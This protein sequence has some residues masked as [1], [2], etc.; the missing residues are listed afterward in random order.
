MADQNSIVTQNRKARHEYHL[1]DK[2]EAGL[3]LVGSEVK[4][5]REGRANLK[6][7]YV[8]IRRGEAVLVSAHISP[9]S[10]TGFTG[11]EPDRDRRLLLNKREILKIN[12]KISEKGF[13]VIPLKIYFKNG[14]AKVEIAVAKGKNFYD[15]R[16]ARKAK[17][18][19]RD[20][21]RQLRNYR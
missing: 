7:S 17:D 13:T 4:S 8:I 10:H 18:V 12:Q 9:Y 11:H 20:T 19:E 21:Q 16:D 14:W 2:F 1:F 3:E 6:D 5:L 15:K